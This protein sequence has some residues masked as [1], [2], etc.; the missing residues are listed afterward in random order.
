M[1]AALKRTAMAAA[2]VTLFMLGTQ[3]AIA[4]QRSGASA[5]SSMPSA[6][7]GSALASAMEDSD[8]LS[9]TRAM[10][11]LATGDQ[12]SWR[13]D[14]TGN[15]YTVK[16]SRWF[17]GNSGACREF[18]ATGEIKGNKE[19]AHGTACKRGDGTW[20]LMAKTTAAQSGQ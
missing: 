12:V 16:A 20:N 19:A 11:T 1:S 8:R 3:G 14:Q 7:A 9:L 17:S 10:D 13:N 15:S 4:Q 6:F 18:D 5:G 2:V